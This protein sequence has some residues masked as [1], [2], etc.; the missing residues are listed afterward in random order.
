MDSKGELH[1]VLGVR[2]ELNSVRRMY[3]EAGNAE[4]SQKPVS[5]P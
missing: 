4:L 2:A 5:P 1:R 3:D